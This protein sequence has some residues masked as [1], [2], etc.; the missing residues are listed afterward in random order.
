MAPL[1]VKDNVIVG[2]SGDFD[3]LSGFLRSVDPETGKTLWQWDST[4]HAGRNP[5][6]DNQGRG[7]DDRDLRS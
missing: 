5:E 2:V 4:S 7:L 1:I 3:N 6:Y